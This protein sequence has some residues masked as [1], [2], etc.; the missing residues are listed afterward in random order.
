MVGGRRHLECEA[1]SVEG[2]VL[3]RLVMVRVLEWDLI[4]MMFGF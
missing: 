4:S 2:W 1:G 3:G